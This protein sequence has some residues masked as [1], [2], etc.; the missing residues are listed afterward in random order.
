MQRLEVGYVARAH[1]LAGEVR[2]HLHAAESTALLD[3][4]HVYLDGRRVAVESARPT[5][6]AIL[7][8]F[9]GVGD[10]DA[11][12]ALRGH[13]VEVDREAVAL[14]PGEYL[15]ADLPGCLVVDG[16]GA[17][18]G[19]VVEVM[20]GPQPILVIHGGGRE[21]LLPAVPRFVLEVDTAGRR[22]IVDLPEDLPAEEL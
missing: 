3:V 18:I 19:T 8:R 13:K 4:D 17:E 12:E 14:A 2:V 16:A 9:E 21:L 11:A 7:V 10:R 6:G 5:V 22:V 1:G 20:A 15:L